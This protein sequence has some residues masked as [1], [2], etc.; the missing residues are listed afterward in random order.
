MGSLH[1]RSKLV[2]SKEYPKLANSPVL[3]ALPYP[4]LFTAQPQARKR[5]RDFC[6]HIRN[7]NTRRDYLEAVW[8]PAQF[9]PVE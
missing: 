6:S 8:R 7:P 2:D 5:M 9:V 3:V 1:Q 4:S